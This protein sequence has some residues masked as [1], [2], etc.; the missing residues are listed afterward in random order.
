M[1]VVANI[2][3]VIAHCYC[4]MGGGGGHLTVH[5]VDCLG[6]E[7]VLVSGCPGIWGSVAPARWQKFKKGMTWM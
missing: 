2:N 1:E 3:K 4:I 6:E 7:T 5:K